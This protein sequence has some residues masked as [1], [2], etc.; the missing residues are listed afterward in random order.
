MGK[1]DPPGPTERLSFG[2][3][4]EEDARW[5]DRIWGDAEVT[6]LIGGPFSPE[7]VAQ[8]LSQEVEN[9]R[10]YGMQYWPL[11]RRRDRDLV[12]CCGL[13]PRNVGTRVAELGFQLCRDSWGQ[14]FAFEA[15]TAVIKWARS[16]GFNALIAGHH[17]DNMASQGVLLRLGFSYTHNEIY[18]PTNTLEPCYLLSLRR[19]PANDRTNTTRS[20]VCDVI[21]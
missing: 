2:L 18:P 5:A 1:L 20:S 12:G 7:A 10:C 17:P 9:W 13:R 14:G 19:L 11:F 16:H 15:S 4:Q 3:W 6:R 8:R 21:P